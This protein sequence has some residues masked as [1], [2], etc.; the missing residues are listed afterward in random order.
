MAGVGAWLVAQVQEQKM[1]VFSFLCLFA[2]IG[3]KMMGVIK[4]SDSAGVSKMAMSLMF[5]PLVFAGVYKADL[6][7]DLWRVAVASTLFHT[8]LITITLVSA[9]RQPLR[10]G[11]RGQWILCSQGTN[12]GV[13]Y[14]FLLA[15]GLRDSIFP[16]FMMWDLAGNAPT[17]L[18]VNLIVA[19]TMAPG[20]Q[21]PEKLQEPLSPSAEASVKK[22]S[23]DLEAGEG[24]SGAC[25]PCVRRAS[26]GSLSSASTCLEESVQDPESPARRVLSSQ[27]LVSGEGSSSGYSKED[28]SHEGSY[29]EFGPSS[30]RS[31]DASQESAQKCE[32][33]IAVA[34]DGKEA[35][36]TTRCSCA[37]R[38]GNL[39]FALGKKLA[40]NL[41][42]VAQIL[43]LTAKF[44]GFT[45]PTLALDF[46]E[47][48]SAPFGLILFFIIGLNLDIEV[49][50]PH[51]GRM[52]KV[53]ATRTVVYAAL[54]G[55]IASLPI[56]TEAAS[57]QTMLLALVCPVSGVGMGYALEYGYNSSV[58]A[59]VLVVS[60][61]VS[62]SVIWGLMAMYSS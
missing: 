51:L 13:V 60:N 50:R 33:G 47:S 46:C 18:I 7:P 32:G 54:G 56:L 8:L 20:N 40:K 58:H 25:Q 2:A 49:I 5:P 15:S 4:M 62:F 17:N 52:F 59:A 30:N 55:L 61:M 12:M 23:D 41:P 24:S 21:L 36:A 48:I 57:F 37:S 39:G 27:D 53:L 9:R 1:F 42:F 28:E 43:A 31:A 16:R 10:D 26:T 19:M 14:P 22:A 35:G 38:L 34:T 29:S 11:I 6:Q 45:V 3:L 44:S